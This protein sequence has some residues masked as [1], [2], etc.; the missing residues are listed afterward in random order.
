MN[1]PFLKLTQTEEGWQALFAFQVFHRQ[2]KDWIKMRWGFNAGALLDE[3]LDRYKLFIESQT[4]N[5]AEFHAGAQPNHTLA[6]RGINSPGIGLQMGL[7]GKACAQE[8][9]EAQRAGVNFARELYSTFPH[10]FL[11]VPAELPGDYNR[12]AGTDIVTANS[13]VAQ[14]Q[15]G[16]AYVPLA[17]S[18]RYFSGLWQASS[19]SN[20]QIWR[21]L[22]VMPNQIIF[23]V[24]IQPTVFYDGERQS[25]LDIKK[26]ISKAE[27]NTDL[28]SA[29]IPW[30]ENY[31]KRRL[32]AW[33][34]FFLLQVHVIANGDL[35]GNL[36]RSI[37]SALTRNANDLPLPG[38][39]IKWPDS[40]DAS[41][42]WR[43]K[44]LTMD[45]IPS[46][47]VEDLVDSDEAFAVF[48]F[49][50]QPEAGLPGAN[51]IAMQKDVPPTHAGQ[52]Q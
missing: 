7:L 27:Q 38:F 31:I 40:N 8:K 5:E 1:T 21:S 24:M 43:E 17:Q 19:R 32:A 41:Q 13:S 20:E 51:F 10:D 46:T 49:P 26:H 23:N 48:R 18:S 14:I 33:K 11:L 35:A 29:Y 15:R 47:R 44:I 36:L 9:E 16:I 30:A 25:L 22:S 28:T 50:Y 2:G 39:Q 34:K 45:L 6:L 37:G 42:T 12:L 52:E 3:A 4:I